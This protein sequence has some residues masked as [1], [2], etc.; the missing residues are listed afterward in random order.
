[1]TQA[2]R[3]REKEREREKKR[4]RGGVLMPEQVQIPSRA[5]TRRIIALIGARDAGRIP[6]ADPREEIRSGRDS[7]IPLPGGEEHATTRERCRVPEAARREPELPRL[8]NPS[9]VKEP[10]RAPPPFVSPIPP[11]VPF[12]SGRRAKFINVNEMILK[13]SYSSRSHS[14]SPPLSLSLSLSCSPSLS[15]SYILLDPTPAARGD[16]LKAFLS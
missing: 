3:E 6:E 9:G 5:I 2:Q 1:M 7:A 14:L 10:R 4:Q 13:S 16:R 8:Q 11:L 12:V 15:F